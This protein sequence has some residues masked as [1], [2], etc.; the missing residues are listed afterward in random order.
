[1]VLV[2]ILVFGLFPRLIVHTMFGSAY[3][4]AIEYLFKFVI[5]MG[6]Y[7]M[8]NFMTLFLLAI[9]KTRVYLLQIP[10][11]ILQAV[12][13]VFFHKDLHQVI[14]MNLLAATFLFI[15]IA[16]FSWKSRGKSVV[17]VQAY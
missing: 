12:L 4:G 6:L 2:G 15:A 9:E 16:A 13:I 14:D 3:E 7:V 17:K 11:V 8:L 5:F 1:M 10:A